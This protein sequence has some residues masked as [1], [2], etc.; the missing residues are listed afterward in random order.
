MTLIAIVT[1]LSLLDRFLTKVESAEVHATAQRSY[2]VGSRLLAAGNPAKAIEPLRDAHAAERQNP[3]Y[4]LALIRAEMEAGKTADA[5]P[6]MNE[7]LM[8]EP[9]D[10]QVNL[11]A[12]R[13]ITKEGDDTDAEAYYHR[14]IYGEWKNDPAAHRITARMEL[15]GDLVKRGKKQELLAELI[16]LGAEPAASPKVREQLAELYSLAGSPSRAAEI[17]REMT[18]KNP[19]DTG[20]YEGLGEAE[21]EQGQYN[22]ARSAFLQGFFRDPNN[23]SLR[24]HLQ[25]LN[26]V[27]GLD[28][29]LRQLTSREKYRRSTRILD[30]TRTGLASC[31]EKNPE[32]GAS[33]ARLLAAADAALSNKVP[34]HVTNEAAESVLAL[35]EAVWRARNG[36]C[37]A[38]SEEEDVLNLLM[39]KL[40]S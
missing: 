33:D 37:S 19:N 12:A 16:S 30:M 36:A 3:E 1:A 35:A 20:A 28:P 9:N 29:T 40:A 27:V 13:L 23:A 24:S 2:T 25:T 8:R 11:I 26:T 14:A 21:L 38:R 17:Y 10:G 18:A 5:E 31:L 7:M 34:A 4:E 15:I 39:K 32:A 22:A 6:L